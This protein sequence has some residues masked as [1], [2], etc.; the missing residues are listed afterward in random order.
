MTVLRD[1]FSGLGN[2]HA[3]LARVLGAGSWLVYS[4]VIINAS[5]HGQALNFLEIGTGF[6]L[7]LSGIGGF[8]WA[9]DTARTAA[10]SQEAKDAGG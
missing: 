1:L 5:V 9:K 7:L 10:V 2:R 3:D 4:G 6:G 8:I